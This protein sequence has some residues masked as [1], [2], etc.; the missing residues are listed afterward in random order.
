MDTS[1]TCAT[2]I[3]HDGDEEA[4]MA[5]MLNPSAAAPAVPTIQLV[6]GDEDAVPRTVPL[7]VAEMSTTIKNLLRDI[8]DG[9]PDGESR[10]PDA[11]IPLSNISD[12][13]LERVLKYCTHVVEMS[14]EEKEKETE[15]E[16][17]EKER[18]AKKMG[19]T[20]KDSD[21]RTEWEKSFCEI[22]T[23]DRIELTMA[24][25]YLHVEPLLDLMIKTL[26]LTLEGKT[27]EEIREMYD[28]EDDLTEEEKKEIRRENGWK[29]DP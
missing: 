4:M 22:S 10:T 5:D 8:A 2:M 9:A 18:G 29:V 17:K 3:V 23:P 21:T 28:I 7:Q 25:N 24:A 20:L 14:D 12:R 19:T 11:P 26:A 15:K 1:E 13:T 27:P 6:A 16:K